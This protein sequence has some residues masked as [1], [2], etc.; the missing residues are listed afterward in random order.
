MFLARRYHYF[1]HDVNR[2]VI[3]LYWNTALFNLATNLSYIFEPIF[4]FNLGFSLVKIMSFYVLV[5][6]SYAVLVIPLTKITAKIGYKH[7]I[8]T[9]SFFYVLYWIVFYQIKFNSD[10]FF[11]AAVLFALQKCFFWPSYN[12]DVAINNVKDQ[13]GREIGVLFSVIEFVGILGPI[14]G[15]FISYQFGF[16]ILFVSSMVLMLASTYPL[17]LSP[18]IYTKHQFYFKNFWVILK[19]FSRNFFGYWGFAEDLMLMSL[20]PIFLFM[21]V[22]G[23]FYVGFIITVASLLAVMIMLY[24]G[25]LIDK[26]QKL[27]ILPISAV[28]YGMTWI[29][30]FL[31]SSLSTVVIFDILTRLG[32]GMVT[33]P[34]ESKTFEIA[35]EKGPDYAIAYS[36][37]FE[38][39]LAVGKIFTALIAIWILSATGSFG[40]VFM[41]VGILTMLYSLIKK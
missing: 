3:E 10:W 31:A 41:A 4:L 6:F 19:K 16:L 26:Y 36:V 5:Y 39:S 18:E 14:L 33:V 25:K 35:G 37:F 21:T 20:W 13:R 23:V 30:R 27:P 9:A 24:L 8:L 34:M 7:A 2:E 11:V 1:S 28:F 38:F 32:K 17:F 12:A 40:L 22:S 29:F 15:G